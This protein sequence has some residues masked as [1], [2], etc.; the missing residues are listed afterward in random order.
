MPFVVEKLAE[1]LFE[2]RS[3]CFQDIKGKVFEI[4][5]L[6]HQAGLKGSYT[7]ARFERLNVVNITVT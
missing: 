1:C 3:N 5:V 2:F 4:N 7:S 6:I